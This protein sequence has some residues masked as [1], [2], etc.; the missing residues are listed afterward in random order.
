[1]N[2]IDLG[3]K[4]HSVQDP[5]KLQCYMKCPR[6]YFL[7]YIMLIQKEGKVHNLEFGK[8]FH[9][10]KD[11]LFT[12]GY[13]ADSVEKAYQA[14][15]EDYRKSYSDA[16]DLDFKGK[17]PANV[18]LALL[19]YVD[20]YKEDKFE[21]LH[22]EIGIA[23]PISDTRTIYGNMDSVMK[24]PRGILSLETKTAAQMWTYAAD[25]FMMSFQIDTYSHFLYSYYYPENNIYGVVVDISVFRKSGVE[26]VRIPCIKT[27]DR[28]E[29]WLW[30]ANEVFDD[31]EE[32]YERLGRVK[33][34]DIIMK[35]FP[36]R[37]VSCVQYN[38]ICPYMDL[39]HAWNNP[40]QHTGETPLGFEFKTW[41]PRDIGNKVMIDLTKGAIK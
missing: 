16:T 11:V 35:A 6:M 17:N 5:T 18:D 4:L 1:M 9:K 40:L 19:S 26:H 27:I 39:C 14:F 7:K 22:T 34:E 12:L 15:L 31:L 13:S 24:G 2:Q 32:D 28:L 33:K 29:S 8:A 21:V 30:Q 37:P 25:N 38:R 23:V 20:E 10:A 3:D 41:D 36:R